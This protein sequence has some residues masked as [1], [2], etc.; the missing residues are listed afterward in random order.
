MKEKRMTKT[1][2]SIPGIRHVYRVP[3]RA[4]Y[5]K[6]RIDA[7]KSWDDVYGR[8]RCD[9]CNKH[10]TEGDVY[11]MTTDLKPVH[12]N[13]VVLDLCGLKKVKKS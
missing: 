1:Q 11:E 4:V 13:C 10:L 7:T 5:N 9:I 3:T 8:A 12:V 6:N 2:S